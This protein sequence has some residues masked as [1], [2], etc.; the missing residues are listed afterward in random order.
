[1]KLFLKKPEETEGM[2]TSLLKTATEEVPNPDLRDR[3]YMY[4]RMLSNDPEVAKAVVLGE[5]P[6]ISEELFM[7]ESSLLDRLIEYISTIASIYHKPPEAVSIKRD[8]DRVIFE[9]EIDREEVVEYDSTGQQLGQ[10]MSPIIAQDLLGLGEFEYAAHS[11]NAKVPLQSVLPPTSPGVNSNTGLHLEAA[12][13]RDQGEILL[14]LRITNMTSTPLSDFIMK[15]NKNCFRLDLAEPLS[16]DVIAPGM[17]H[18]TQIKVSSSGESDNS[19]PSVPFIVQMAL[20]CS[21][22]IFYFTT[23]CMYSVLLLE[24]GKLSREVFRDSWLAIPDSNVF[25]HAI[26]KIHSDWYSIEKIS[27][28]LEHNNIF[29]VASTT[30]EDGETVLFTSSRDVTNEC[31]L[32]EMRIPGSLDRISVSCRVMQ[33]GLAPLFIQCIN[34]LIATNS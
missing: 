30:S 2:I 11:K 20:K 25:V 28:R 22:D 26:P 13:Q 27:K 3:A 24:S 14:E 19:T 8:K 4:W 1:M 17:S 31:V 29:I 32:S 33:A 23:P 16:V 12:F 5:K 34:F 10:A 15:F 21:L 6:T 18:F 7:L 9:R